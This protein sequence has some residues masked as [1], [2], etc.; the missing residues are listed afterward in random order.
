MVILRK[1]SKEYTSLAAD[2][3]P[4]RERAV[5]PSLFEGRV[6]VGL[7]DRKTGKKGIIMRSNFLHQPYYCE[8]NIWQLAK[9]LD[10]KEAEV[11]FIINENKTIATAQQRAVAV[12]SWVIWDYHVVYYS[13]DKGILD[14]DTRCTFPC[15]V[16]TYLTASF[17]SIASVITEAHKPYF[18]IIPANEYLMLF[19]SNREHMLDHEGNYTQ[20]S[21][22]WPAIGNGNNLAS[23]IDYNDESIGDII[24]LDKLRSRY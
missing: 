15:A 19:A 16:D 8:E 23:F 9:V 20:P 10:E 18:R 5:A 4:S 3:L 11:W 2:S 13:P 14:L 12:N 21:P 17:L 6:G 7:K 22:E 24:S 1:S